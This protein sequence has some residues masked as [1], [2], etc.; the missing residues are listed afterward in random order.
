MN[1]CFATNGFNFQFEPTCTYL[2][3]TGVMH[4]NSFQL[5]VV[6]SE[7]KE[8]TQTIHKGHTLSNES[9]VF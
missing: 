9:K 7:G 8:V 3:I 6:K 4:K 2:L 1:Q 5:S